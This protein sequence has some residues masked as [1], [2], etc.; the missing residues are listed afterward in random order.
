MES[1]GRVC[2]PGNIVVVIFEKYN[3]PLIPTFP[4][5]EPP[6]GLDPYTML[7]NSQEIEDEMTHLVENF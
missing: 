2:G 3:P 7:L 4:H 1:S 6:S 5:R